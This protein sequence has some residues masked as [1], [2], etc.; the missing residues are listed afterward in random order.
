MTKLVVD[1]HNFTDVCSDENLGSCTCLCVICN[2]AYFVTISCQHQHMLYCN[3][4][5][6]GCESKGC[7]IILEE[8]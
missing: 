7:C 8:L 5:F 3:F 1:F 2:K 6:G 4:L